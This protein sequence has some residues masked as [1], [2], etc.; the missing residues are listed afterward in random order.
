M[1]TN[2][3]MMADKILNAKNPTNKNLIHR[4]AV[5]LNPDQSND[6]D[7]LDL[8]GMFFATFLFATD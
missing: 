4:K 5:F 7:D 3:K 8:T 2:L 6:A 1:G